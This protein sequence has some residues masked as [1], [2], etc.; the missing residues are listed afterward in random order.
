MQHIILFI[1]VKRI[2]Q[3]QSSNVTAFTFFFLFFFVFLLK[4]GGV[5]LKKNSTF[6]TLQKYG[7]AVI[8]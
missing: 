1:N 2:V 7:I 5:L 3:K 6:N 8:Y 4:G